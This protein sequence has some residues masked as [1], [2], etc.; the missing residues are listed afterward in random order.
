LK[1]VITPSHWRWPAKL[2]HAIPSK[3]L[4]SKS[5][6]EPGAI[7]V[8]LR[9]DESSLPFRA[10]SVNLVGICGLSAHE[11]KRV[12]TKVNRVCVNIAHVNRLLKATKSHD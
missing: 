12:K 8:Q 10:I 1:G 9:S 6:G 3:L 5:A 7:C 11:S 4:R 2:L